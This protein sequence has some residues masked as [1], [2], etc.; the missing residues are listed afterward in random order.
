MSTRPC[1]CNPNHACMQHARMLNRM[2]DAFR[3]LGPVE[4]LDWLAT[5]FDGHATSMAEHGHPAPW[6]DELVADARALVV[7]YKAMERSG[8]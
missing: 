4:A 3:W 7:K 2:L 1:G 6:V 5:Y 8:R